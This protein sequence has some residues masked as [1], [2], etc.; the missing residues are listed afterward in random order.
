[1]NK[2]EWAIILLPFFAI[3]IL[4]Q[5]TKMWAIG[6]QE[7]MDF[8]LVHIKLNLNQGVILGFFSDLPQLL[9]V[10]SLS[11]GGAFLLFFY[12][13]SQYIITMPALILRSGMTLF[14]GGI[15][16]NV[17]DRI[18]WGFVVDFLIVG[19]EPYQTAIFNLADVSQLVGFC[20][21]IYGFIK[22]GD[23]LWPEKEDRKTFWVNKKFQ[24][25]YCLILTAAGACLSLI[26]LTFCYTYLRIIL[27]AFP[28]MPGLAV[29]QILKS[30]IAIYA[31]ISL[32]FCLCLF[33]FGKF[34]SH[35]IA[36]PLYAFER[37]LDNLLDGKHSE[38]KLRTG[39]EF[40]HLEEVSIKLQD[41]LENLK[42]N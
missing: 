21:I 35:R 36:G 42:L 26:T 22:E 34:V 39:D 3:I 24:L 37:F 7:S 9:R 28:P 6:L 30:F 1:M 40:K 29:D 41:K 12:L 13:L 23:R 15:L 4:D 2:K 20:L 5:V 33:L 17:I 25:K 38:L 32:V 11:T 16:G 14:I 18:H 10:V 27:A 8:F 31:I 19:H